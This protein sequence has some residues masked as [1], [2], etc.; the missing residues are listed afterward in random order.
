MKSPQ[1]KRLSS[2][3]MMLSIIILG[4]GVVMSFF[5]FSTEENLKHDARIINETGT[6]RGAIQRVTKFTLS[7]SF[8]QANELTRQINILINHYIQIEII[9]QSQTTGKVAIKP[10]QNL[11]DNWKSLESM[12]QAYQATPS[13]LLKNKIFHQSEKCWHA[14]DGVVLHAQLATEYKVGG[15]RMFYI[16]LILNGLTT[17]LV[18]F[19]VLKYVRHKLEYDTSH[20][21]LTQLY[22]RRSYDDFINSEISRSRRY[23]SSLSLILFDVDYFKKIND[24][25]GHDR[26][27]TVLINIAQIVTGS[28]RQSDALFRIGGEEFAIISPETSAEGA[29]TLAE[30]IRQNVEN[31]LPDSSQHVT[32][33]LGVSEYAEALSKNDFFHDTDQA[34]YRAK[35]RGRNQTV[36]FVRKP[37]LAA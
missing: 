19:L 7:G 17:I 15:I 20:D 24:Q 10:M 3:L 16:I 2:Y 32:I 6:I 29:F 34:L 21:P 25:F 1:K 11:K 14:A 30:K 9:H 27:D 23:H 33:S 8:H 12:I 13:P 5:I 36:V 35:N 22:N 4:L 26:G 28:I 18:L 37:S 31:F